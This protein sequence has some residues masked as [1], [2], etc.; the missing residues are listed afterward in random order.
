MGCHWKKL[1]HILQIVLPP[2]LSLT[3]PYLREGHRESIEE[4]IDPKIVLEIDLKIDLKMPLEK[5]TVDIA[6]FRN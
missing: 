4:N 1:W 5:A 2:C 6:Q 3:S